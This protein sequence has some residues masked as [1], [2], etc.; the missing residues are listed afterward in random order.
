[1]DHAGAS[2]FRISVTHFPPSIFFHFP[3]SPPPP[4]PPPSTPRRTRIFYSHRGF[5]NS[6]V[7]FGTTF[8]PLTMQKV[9]PNETFSSCRLEKCSGNR[10]Y[11]VYS[12]AN[13]RGD[14]IFFFFFGKYTID[15]Y[16]RRLITQ[17]IKFYSFSMG[18]ILFIKP[19]CANICAASTGRR[20][21][22]IYQYI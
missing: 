18:K 3:P 1:M 9:W 20:I 12:P 21:K 5:D 13:C 8:Y 11:D 22:I 7:L 6:Y 4:T 17:R 19:V 15:T 2:S 10:R 16:T 14:S